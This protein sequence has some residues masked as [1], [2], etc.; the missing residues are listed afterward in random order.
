M[1]CECVVYLFFFFFYCEWIQNGGRYSRREQSVWAV[2]QGGLFWSLFSCSHNPPTQTPSGRKK[3]SVLEK[4]I[5]LK[6]DSQTGGYWTLKFLLKQCICSS[7]S[8]PFTIGMS[9]AQVNSCNCSTNNKSTMN[10]TQMLLLLKSYTVLMMN[11]FQWPYCTALYKCSSSFRDGWWA[12]LISK[13][14]D[15]FR[16]YVMLHPLCQA[17]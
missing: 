17:R 10:V 2:W 9:S 6:L 16:V 5:C 1:K 8:M 13:Q 14:Q 15:G 4:H 3:S 12:E 7:A 11:R